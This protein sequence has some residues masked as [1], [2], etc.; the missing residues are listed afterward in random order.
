MIETG[1]I[2][3]IET[4]ETATE[5]TEI[6]ETETE[7]IEETEIAEIEEIEETEKETEETQESIEEPKK[8]ERELK[9]T[10]ETATEATEI[11]GSH[12]IVLLKPAIKIT[13]NKKT[14]LKPP[15]ILKKLI[16]PIGNGVAL[17]VLQNPANVPNEKRIPWKINTLMTI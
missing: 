7:E 2:V 15:G 6:E 16:P 8:E 17:P 12:A 13:T 14:P 10:A 5:E 4:E 11:Y 1:T 3:E 9:E